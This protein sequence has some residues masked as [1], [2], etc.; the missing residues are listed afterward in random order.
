[1]LNCTVVLSLFII[2]FSHY[3]IF[4]IKLLDDD[5]FL[6]IDPTGE[7]T[8]PLSADNVLQFSEDPLPSA[9]LTLSLAIDPPNGTFTPTA[10]AAYLWSDDTSANIYYTLDGSYPTIKSKYVNISNPYLLLESTDKSSYATVTAIAA[11]YDNNFQIWYRSN[12][13]SATYEIE[14]GQRPHR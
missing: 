9:S 11:K 6:A 4:G 5:V 1:M 10:L 7:T 8:S 13:I 12:L 2:F 14:S 3:R